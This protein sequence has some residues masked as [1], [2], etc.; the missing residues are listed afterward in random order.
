MGL[1]YVQ[2]NGGTPTVATKFTTAVVSGGK[3]TLT[4]TGTGSLETAPKADGPWTP[5]TPS[6]TSPYTE[7]VLAG[8]N[9]F[10]RLKQ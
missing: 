7:D 5:V 1:D 10:Y 3:V 4:W 6:P 8:Q 2:L 9:R